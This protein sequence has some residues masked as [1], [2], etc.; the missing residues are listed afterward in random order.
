MWRGCLNTFLI[1]KG[2]FLCQ[3]KIYY[4]KDRFNIYVISQDWRILSQF[5]THGL[6]PRSD[7]YNPEFNPNCNLRVSGLFNDTVRADEK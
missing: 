3:S 2:N 5:L 6:I 4:E 1:L 7:L